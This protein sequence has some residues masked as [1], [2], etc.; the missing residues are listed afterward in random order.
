[1]DSLSEQEVLT[2]VEAAIRA[3]SIHNTQPWLFLP[4]AEGIEVFA[5]L[6]RRLAAIDPRGRAMHISL[7]AAV[8]NLRIALAYGGH[9]EQTRLLPDPDDP[10]HVATVRAV[11]YLSAGLDERELFVAIGRR[12]SNRGPFDDISPPG[13]DL[14]RLSGAADLEGATL[15][16]ADPADR[17]ALLSLARTAEARRQRD[18]AYRAELIAWTTDDPYRE[19]GVP[20][21]AVGPWSEREAMPIRDFAPEREIPG[22][23]EVRFELEPVVGTLSVRGGDE[24][25]QWL[26][27]GQALQRVLLEATRCGLATSLFSQPLEDSE[28]RDLLRDD[29]QCTS[30]QVVLRV[31]YAPPAPASPRR[32]P[33]EVIV[34]PVPLRPPRL[35]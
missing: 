23:R 21:D 24:P 20:L 35:S 33:E 7:G 15:H 2:A 6:S 26:R 19:D 8:L 17:D 10:R 5:D 11:G 9:I 31:G 30:V 4:S 27:A 29:E 14:D 16:V 22:R 34:R 25:E 32:P 18:S 28:L 13:P 1:M 12:R 3:P